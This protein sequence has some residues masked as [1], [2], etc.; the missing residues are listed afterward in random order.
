MG[1]IRALT[2]N[3]GSLALMDAYGRVARLL[4]ESA[5]TKEGVQFVP[6]RLTQAEIASRVGCTREMVSRIFKDLVQ[7]Q[8]ISLEADRIVIHRVPPARG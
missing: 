8:Y 5:V 3:V 6:E 7:R 2:R 4:L 1:R